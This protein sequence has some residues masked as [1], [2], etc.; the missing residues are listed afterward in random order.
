M[1]GHINMKKIII[2]AGFIV[3]F[4]ISLMYAYTTQTP[5][6]TLSK[7]IMKPAS[8]STPVIDPVYAL[9]NQGW[10]GK[11]LSV[12]ISN[13][14]NNVKKDLVKNIHLL[15]YP[16]RISSSKN[17]VSFV[18]TQTPHQEHA[19]TTNTGNTILIDNAFL[20]KYS[21]NPSQIAKTLS[22]ELGHSLGLLHTSTKSIMYPSKSS[23]QT[24]SLN[25]SQ[26]TYLRYLSKTNFMTKFAAKLINI[27]WSASAVNN[28]TLYQT[29]PDTNLSIFSSPKLLKQSNI[30]AIII[31][32]NV[33]PIMIIYLAIVLILTFINR[34]RR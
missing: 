11:Y 34:K 23:L 2:I 8:T 13:L 21:K 24:L 12:N 9:N 17:A 27:H 1:K 20:H 32:M 18:Y 6:Y 16:I 28:F 33:L 4:I 7:N 30:S 15:G 5:Y 25:N 31:L 22:H 29:M 19:L 14:P 10:N 3:I 26:K